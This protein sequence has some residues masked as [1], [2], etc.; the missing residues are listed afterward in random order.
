MK[1]IIRWI[2]IGIVKHQISNHQADIM[3][4]CYCSNTWEAEYEYLCNKLEKLRK[5]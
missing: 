1:R 5:G 2:K 4:Q 3:S